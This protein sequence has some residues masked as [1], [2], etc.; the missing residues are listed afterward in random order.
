MANPTVRAIAFYLQGKRA[1]TI[2]QD[3]IDETFGRTPFYGAEGLAGHSKGAGMLRFEATGFVPV[4][5]SAG[6]DIRAKAQ[7]QEDLEVGFKIGSQ[8]CRQTM[9]CLGI[10]TTSNTQTGMTEEVITL[11]GPM[12]KVVG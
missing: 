10:R 9:A 7:A 4:S 1:A 2:S 3:N 11:E 5:G 6:N 12:P 8:F